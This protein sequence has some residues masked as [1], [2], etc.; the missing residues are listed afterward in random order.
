MNGYDQSYP[1][2][3]DHFKGTLVCLSNDPE[4]FSSMQQ[5]CVNFESQGTM[6]LR[7]V[8]QGLEGSQ[9]QK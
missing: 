3:A 9:F 6:G 8:G 5:L 1:D 2:H 7:R 4:M